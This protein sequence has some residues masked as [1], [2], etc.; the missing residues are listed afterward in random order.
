MEN[1]IQFKCS[2][3]ALPSCPQIEHL[4]PQIGQDEMEPEELWKKSVSVLRDSIQGEHC[5]KNYVR[6]FAGLCSKPN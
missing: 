1:A 4:Y 3:K 6:F 2:L 5:S